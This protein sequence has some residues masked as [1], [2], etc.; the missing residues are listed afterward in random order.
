MTKSGPKFK[1]S[2]DLAIDL[3]RSAS[4]EL[5]S[6]P[7]AGEMTIHASPQETL[8]LIRMYVQIADPRVRQRCLDFVR[9]S[10]S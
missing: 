3:L 6:D 2:L 5:T 9:A 7:P 10:L 4:S 8:T 1:E